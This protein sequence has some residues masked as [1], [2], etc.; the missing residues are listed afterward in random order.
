MKY[1]GTDGIRGRVGEHPL[2]P[3][4]AV[5][6]GWAFG[7]TLHPGVTVV[8]GKDTR[9]SSDML[10]AGLMTGL[11]YAG[12]NVV[13]IGV[14]PT[15]AVAFTVIDE[16]DAGIMIT[17]SHNPY[18][19]NGF[20]FF[21]GNGHKISK[22]TRGAIE[23]LL[24]KKMVFSKKPGFHSVNGTAINHYGDALI[25]SIG[26]GTPVLEDLKIVVDCANGA[27]SYIAP[28]V[29][30]SLGADVKD[31][32]T[33]PDGTNINDYCG[34]TAPKDIQYV[35]KQ[36]SADV[37]IAFDGDG[38]RLIM[39]DRFGNIVDGDSILYILATHMHKCPGVVGTVMTNAGVVQEFHNQGIPFHRADVG[40][41][42]VVEM[43]QK[44]SLPLGAET[45]GH[46]LMPDLLPTGDA[47][48]AALHV[49]DKVRFNREI[50]TNSTNLKRYPNI[51][52]N[53]SVKD[54][55]II[56]DRELIKVVS[57]TNAA[58][59]GKG[60]ILVRPSGTEP[61]IR[62]MVEHED[63]LV[64]EQTAKLLS[65]LIESCEK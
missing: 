44:Y 10:E 64:A 51:L 22:F 35:V 52:I 20:K 25:N 37:G 18:Q 58:F 38:D 62:V 26:H 41:H 49:L 5:R 40:D 3:D 9:E 16:Y 46:V 14:C 31:I 60:R 11:M 19:D 29:L 43:L 61:I 12:C 56:K 13:T 2:T 54:K 36:Q 30:R 24:E 1:F 57:G 27:M 21:F 7:A 23:T 63:G 47:L 39:C 42:N 32:Y 59:A 45:S 28:Q 8:I 50:L 17:A 34:A 53:V 4:F 48:L 33:V 15:P 55:G 6:L 65:S